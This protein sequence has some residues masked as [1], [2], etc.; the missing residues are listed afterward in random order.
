MKVIKLAPQIMHE[1][2]FAEDIFQGALSFEEAVERL[3]TEAA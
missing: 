3:T 2:R 1:S